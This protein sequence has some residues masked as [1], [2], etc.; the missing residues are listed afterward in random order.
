MKNLGAPKFF[1]GAPKKKELGAPVQP[2]QKVSLE[3]WEYS[4]EADA[5]YRYPCRMFQGPSHLLSLILPRPYPHHTQ[6]QQYRLKS[7]NPAIRKERKMHLFYTLNNAKII[8]DS[9]S[10]P[11][12]LLTLTA[13][14]FQL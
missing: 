9:G 11:E 14:H 8:W 3:P 6:H 13:K 5:A 7:L 10:K 1:A 2:V 4:V 12:G